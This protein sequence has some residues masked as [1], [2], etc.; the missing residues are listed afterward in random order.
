METAPLT[1]I[2]VFRF[3]HILW[4]RDLAQY[5]AS[6]EPAGLQHAG[7]REQQLHGHR[8]PNNTLPS[9]NVTPHGGN[10]NTGG[11][12]DITQDSWGWGLGLGNFRRGGHGE[13]EGDIL[14][15]KRVNLQTSA[16]KPKRHYLQHVCLLVDKQK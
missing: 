14:E 11:Q 2:A 5:G 7:E 10:N 4:L 9:A 12:A 8:Y 16:S 13:L 6:R 15:L 1:L 3:P